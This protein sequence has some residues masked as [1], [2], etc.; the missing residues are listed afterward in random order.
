MHGIMQWYLC[1]V[2]NIM[3]GILTLMCM[4]ACSVALVVFHSLRPYGF[5]PVRLLCPWNSPDKNTGVGCHALL[6]GIF[7]T[8]GSNPRLLRLLHWEA[9]SLPTEPRGKPVDLATWRYMAFPWRTFQEGSLSCPFI[10]TPTS[11]L[12]LLLLSPLATTNFSCI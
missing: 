4:H 1:D 3:A 12:P 8:Q 2:Y 11:L 9:D 5:Y 6:Q 10:S 7:P